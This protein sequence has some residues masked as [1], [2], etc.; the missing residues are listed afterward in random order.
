M[1][2]P[3]TCFLLALAAVIVA[4]CAKGSLGRQQRDCVQRHQQFQHDYCATNILVAV[5]GLAAFRAWVSNP[6]NP[7]DVLNRDSVIFEVDARLFLIEERLGETNGA[8]QFYREA[9]EAHDR[10]HEY[11]QSLHLP[12]QACQLQPITSKDQLRDL[13]D[14]Q[15]KHFDVGW[16]QIAETPK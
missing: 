14:H 8:E 4:S 3:V 10:Y 12:D 6:K 15:D 11:I 2:H 1:K 9:V 13:V 16:E 5:E 7:C